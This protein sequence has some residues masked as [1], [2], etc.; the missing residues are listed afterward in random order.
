M[1]E[2]DLEWIKK[3]ARTGD[4]ILCSGGSFFSFVIKAVTMSSFSHIG[5]IIRL[6]RE[7]SSLDLLKRDQVYVLQS[8]I[9]AESELHDVLQRELTLDG[10]QVNTIE[11]VMEVEKHMYYKQLLD[12]GPFKKRPIDKK[13]A[14]ILKDLALKPYERDL[15]ELGNSVL[16]VNTKAGPNSYFCSELVVAFYF[17]MGFASEKN[18][19]YPNNY[20]PASFEEGNQHSIVLNPG[21]KFGELLK[22]T[23]G[24]SGGGAVVSSGGTMSN[25]KTNNKQQGSCNLQ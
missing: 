1:E 10:V 2:V 24:S 18:N 21:Y 4:I 16:G 3:N 15:L 9:H 25:D 11:S 5:V 8:T 7:N 17:L 6:E 22:V 19:G 23:Y 12:D 14:L 13:R 20:T